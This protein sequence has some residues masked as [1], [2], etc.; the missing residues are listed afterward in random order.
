MA[1]L[2][3]EV[4][5]FNSSETIPIEKGSWFWENGK[6][7]GIELDQEEIEKLFVHLYF[8]VECFFL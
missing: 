3:S 5:F 4:C 8:I 6:S 1:T 2:T 7:F